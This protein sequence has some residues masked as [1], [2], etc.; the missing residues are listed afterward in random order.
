M[1]QVLESLLTETKILQRTVLPKEGGAVIAED[2]PE[3]KG[4]FQDQPGMVIKFGELGG[5]RDA[6]VAYFGRILALL[7]FDVPENMF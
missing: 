5:K 1:V 3:R 4:H 6:D 7:S 2:T